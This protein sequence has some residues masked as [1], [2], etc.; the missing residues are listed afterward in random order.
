MTKLFLTLVNSSL[1]WWIMHVVL[2]NEKSGNIFIRNY[3]FLANLCF[4]ITVQFS[5]QL[6]FKDKIISG[7]IFKQKWRLLFIHFS[8]YVWDWNKSGLLSMKCRPQSY[9][10]NLSHP[11]LILGQ[12]FLFSFILPLLFLLFIG[13]Y[14]HPEQ[15]MSEFVVILLMSIFFTSSPWACSPAM[16]CYDPRTLFQ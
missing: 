8:H 2:T 11:N 6:M 3:L 1:L 16:K 4:Q 15:I 12:T 5:E 14:F 13:F 7:H 9:S 10:C